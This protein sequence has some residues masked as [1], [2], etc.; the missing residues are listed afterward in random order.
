[1]KR[2]ILLAAAV[3]SSTVLLQGCANL[4]SA[5]SDGVALKRDEAS[6]PF[7]NQRSAVTS[8]QADGRNGLWVEGGRG[9]WY[10]ARFNAPC[11][12]VENAVRLGFDTG[13]SDRL[14]RFSHV[15]VPNE[16]ERCAIISF[17]K[18]DPPPDGDRRSYDSN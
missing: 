3:A 2:L 7:A 18:S 13:T 6:I 15:I 11:V 4:E 12:G 14:D 10:Y 8:F 16:P 9:D 5:T 17:T 1:M